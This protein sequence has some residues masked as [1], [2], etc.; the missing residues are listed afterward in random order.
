MKK[1]LVV[2]VNNYLANIG[3]FAKSTIS[4]SALF[5]TIMI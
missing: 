4:I 1:E 5:F 2:Q 3:V